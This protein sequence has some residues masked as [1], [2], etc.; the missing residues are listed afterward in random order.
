MNRPHA[1]VI[2]DD[3]TLSQVYMTALRQA[4]FDTALDM[5][6]DQYPTL[7]SAAEPDIVVLDLHLPYADS[8]EVFDAIRARSPKTIIVIVT[9]DFIKARIFEEK[10]DYVLIKPVSVARLMKIAEAVKETS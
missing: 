4:G 9:A 3:P 1:L 6:G 7:L 5:N 8:A 2:E 10:A